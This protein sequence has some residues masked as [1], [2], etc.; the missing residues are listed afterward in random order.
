MY[1]RYIVQTVL[2][3]SRIF[4]QLKKLFFT[5]LLYKLFLKKAFK[6]TLF[7]KDL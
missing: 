1:F 5:S 3:L 4:V 7:K 6:F 2:Q